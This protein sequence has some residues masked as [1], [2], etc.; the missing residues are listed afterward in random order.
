VSFDIKILVGITL[1]FIAYAFLYLGKCLQK[2]GIEGF[3]G[4][5]KV[6]VKNKHGVIWIFGILLASI[7]MFVQWVALFFAPINL[8]APIEGLGLIVLIIFSF[9]YLKESINKLQIIGITLIITGTVIITYFNINPSEIAF[10]N[11]KVIPFLITLL[12]ISATE[13]LLITLGKI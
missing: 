11:F 10:A 9:F 3:K 13:L 5:G 6:S 4:Q 7:H 1:G 12:S 2:H 8:I